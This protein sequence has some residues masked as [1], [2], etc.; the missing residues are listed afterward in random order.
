MLLLESQGKSI[1]QKHGLAT[2]I[3][4]N[5]TNASELESA[6]SALSFPV[7]LKAQVPTGARGKNGGILFA[8]DQ[9]QALSAMTQLLGRQVINHQVDQILV[10]PRIDI[11]AE[12][13]LAAMIFEEEIHIMACAHG[14]VDI[15]TTASEHPGKIALI[16]APDDEGSTSELASAL[17]NAGFP[18]EMLS[19]YTEI[20]LKLRHLMKAN[21]AVLVEINPLVETRADELVALDAKIDIDDAAIERQRAVASEAY[22]LLQR[23]YSK[24]QLPRIRPV[25]EG[26][27]IGLIGLG[28]G[29]N[30]SIVDWFAAL[31]QP[32][33]ALT[34]IDDA[35]AYDR[36]TEFVRNCIEALR[37]DHG[38]VG[39]LINIISC[40]YALDQVARSIVP[41][42][43][44]V[45]GQPIPVVLNVHGRLGLE[46]NQILDEAGR[47]NAKNLALAIEQLITEVAAR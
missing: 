31:G 15:E 39:V 40:N 24:A 43:E 5:V 36:V 11:S 16:K 28:G 12:R 8:S 6:V 42:L 10:E 30:L 13:Y 35:I 3:G 21:D 47:G 32:V 41:A 4:Y 1:L 38:A 19:R 7:A 23:D 29:L 22:P 33:T 44:N 26:G 46:A 14:G 34:D 37:D 17:G 27:S 25:T 18:A 20:C 45:A 2:P 9:D